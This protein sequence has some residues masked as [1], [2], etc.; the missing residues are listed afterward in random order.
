MIAAAAAG[1]VVSGSH[2][3]GGSGDGL[4]P[5]TPLAPRP[6]PHSEFSTLSAAGLFAGGRPRIKSE[7]R[8]KQP[9]L[10]NVRR[11][12]GHMGRGADPG[13]GGR[14]RGGHVIVCGA[15]MRDPQVSV[16]LSRLAGCANTRS[17]CT[18]GLTLVHTFAVVLCPLLYPAIPVATC[19][20]LVPFMRVRRGCA[21]G[22]A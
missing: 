2:V 8:A 15:C 18:Y 6:M 1:A 9:V 10:W 11:G 17:R 19:M 3:R 12:A 20:V 16:D 4:A 5:P 7:A 21:C 22:W 13:G 14:G